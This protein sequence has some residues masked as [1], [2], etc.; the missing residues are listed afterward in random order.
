[1]IKGIIWDVDGVIL[2]SERLHAETESETAKEFGINITP[3][4]V[5]RLYSGIHIEEEFADMAKRA[6]KEIPLKRVVAIIK[7]ILRKKLGGKIPLIPHI[8]EV[9]ESLRD[10]YKL[11]FATSGERYFIESAL[12]QN[13]LTDF[14]EVR[15][16][17]RD[18]KVPKPDPEIFLRAASLLKLKPDNIAVIEDSESGFKAAKA[19]G[20]LLIAR[21]AEHNK[22]K[23]F[24]LAGYVIKDLRE[25]PQVLSMV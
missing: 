11:A 25:I 15:V 24:S 19:A 1:M 21:K 8:K 9:L 17:V 18:V 20:M 3:Q 7:K 6:N 23:D 22:N 2:D 13:G 12:K 14:F 16:Y 10:R 4:E 5:T